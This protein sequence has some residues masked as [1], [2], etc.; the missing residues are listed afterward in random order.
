MHIEP[1]RGLGV[2]NRCALYSKVNNNTSFT[3]DQNKSTL[4][5]CSIPSVLIQF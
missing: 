2:S 1:S 4:S 5:T 3:C